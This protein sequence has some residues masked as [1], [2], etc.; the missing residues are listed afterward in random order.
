M[1][2]QNFYSMMMWLPVIL[3][4]AGLTACGL[5]GSD[6]S[7]DSL[8]GMIVFSASDDDGKNQIFTM[9][10]DGSEL[11]QLTH[12][13]FEYG[14]GNDGAGFNGYMP[15]WSPDGRQILF[16][17]FYK[18]T[19]IGPSIWVMNADG[20]NLQPVKEFDVEGEHAFHALEG[21]NPRWSP[22]G[23]K[24]A[25]HLCVN[26]QV[27]TNHAI[28]VFDLETE[29]FTR[30][31]EEPRGYSSMNPAWSPDGS[32]I[33][34]TA[35]RDYVD[36]DTDR[37]RRDLYVMD[38]DGSNQTRVTETG[39]PGGYIWKNSDHIIQTVTDRSTNLK[40]VLLLEIETGKTTPIIENL[41][42]KNQFWVFRDPL[43]QQ[44]LTVNR[45]HDE[46][47]VIIASY[48]LNGSISNQYV[49]NTQVL[50]SGFGYDW[51]V[52]VEH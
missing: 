5:L 52:L 12:S 48:D 28:F 38:A 42:V 2:W 10:P 27:S 46:L 32:R 30:L 8:S 34:F 33:A 16:S 36:A 11:K 6:A 29:E 14:P 7:E 41:E 1:N 3:V 22:D 26:C 31:T 9:Q 35:N 4:C 51:H 24:L 49:L 43:S 47:P 40:D 44:L 39:Y 25:F 15:S 17:S 20:S 45:N 19:S 18:A 21:N 37:W 23:T 50:Q 13:D